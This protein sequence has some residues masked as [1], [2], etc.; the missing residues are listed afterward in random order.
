MLICEFAKTN[1]SS[2]GISFSLSNNPLIKLLC[3]VR[4][5]RCIRS[6]ATM[7]MRQSNAARGHRLT[8]LSISEEQL[9]DLDLQAKSAEA[10]INKHWVAK[11]MR[12]V[13]LPDLLIEVV[14]R[15]FRV[16]ATIRGA[17]C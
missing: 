9:E 7:Q 1:L 3:G 13:K 11:H 6:G 5:R 15:P 16:L 14:F 12:R 2:R 17:W 10:T 8:K 4:K